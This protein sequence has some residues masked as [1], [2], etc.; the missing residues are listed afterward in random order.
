MRIDVSTCFCC[1]YKMS[2][3]TDEPGPSRMKRK[4]SDPLQG[5]DETKHLAE[6]RFIPSSLDG[7]EKIHEQAL[8]VV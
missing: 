8:D 1:R 5:H 4:N 2:V 7:L 6:D 3:N